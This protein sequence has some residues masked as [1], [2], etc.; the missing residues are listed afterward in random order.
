M[1]R[2]TLAI[3]LKR[4]IEI[5]VELCIDSS[6]VW[7]NELSVW[8]PSDG[9]FNRSIWSVSPFVSPSVAQ[10][11]QVNKAGLRSS[12]PAGYSLLCQQQVRLRCGLIWMLKTSETRDLDDSLLGAESGRVV[13]C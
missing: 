13:L 11:V 1:R 7:Y 12:F 3:R 10:K 2:L 8:S 6:I 4:F 9:H 5:Y